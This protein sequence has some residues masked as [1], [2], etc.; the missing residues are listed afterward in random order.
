[1][2]KLFGIIALAAGAACLLFAAVV[3]IVEACSGFAL[4]NYMEVCGGGMIAADVFF[5]GSVFLLTFSSARRGNIDCLLEE[6]R[7]SRRN[8]KKNAGIRLFSLI[9]I[10]LYVLLTV[11]S[12]FVNLTLGFLV[13]VAG[14]AA[15]AIIY[16]ALFSSL[17]KKN[18]IRKKP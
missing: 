9:Y 17:I 10:G 4:G 16:A 11:L 14:L 12:F 15:Y 13:L 8:K 3:A 2:M 18:K 6:G 1:M 5:G 7:F